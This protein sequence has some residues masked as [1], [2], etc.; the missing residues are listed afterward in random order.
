MLLVCLK[1]Y[2][3][4]IKCGVCHSRCVVLYEQ[5]FVL[6][7]QVCCAVFRDVLFCVVMHGIL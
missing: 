4:I 3:C 7:L 1:F 2:F 6:F 5:V